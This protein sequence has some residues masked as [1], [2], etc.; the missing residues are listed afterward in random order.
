M[1]LV[2]DGAP[3]APPLPTASAAGSW[4]LRAAMRTANF[5]LLVAGTTLTLF[6]IGTVS[7]HLILYL[8]DVR[9][10]PRS[11]SYVA[12]AML[13]SSLAGR[14]VVGHLAD[15]YSKKNLMALFYFLLAA[16]VP[17]LLLARVPSVPWVFAALFGF[18][19]GADFILIPLLTAEC[20][21]LPSLGRLLTFI[22]LTYSIAQFLGPTV[23]GKIYDVRHSYALAWA[24][25]SA[26]GIAGAGL[27]YLVK[28]SRR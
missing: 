9:Y 5:W 26:V 27:I 8:V 4:T 13:A 10:S 20:F 6:T 24:L 11:A 23:A 12:S 7:Q 18:A 21:G 15:R 16:I 19:M 3:A 25:N 14:V 22:I 1:G 17:L 28:P 2:A